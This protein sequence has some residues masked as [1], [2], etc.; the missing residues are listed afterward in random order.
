[1]L[2]DLE[3]DTLPE[4]GVIEKQV[5]TDF[6]N[7]VSVFVCV[8]VPCMA[9]TRVRDVLSIMSCVCLALVCVP[10][11]SLTTLMTTT[12]ADGACEVG[13]CKVCRSCS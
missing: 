7:K 5:H 13:G 3:A 2:G 12:S 9:D 11:S 6:F 1:M 10:C 4:G 8:C